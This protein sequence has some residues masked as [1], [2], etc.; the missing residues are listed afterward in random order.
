MVQEKKAAKYSNRLSDSA[1]S[2]FL[3]K[4]KYKSHWYGRELVAIGQ[5]V[6]SSKMCN[7]CNHIMDYMG[8]E[9]REWTCPICGTHHD[10]DINAAINILHTALQVNNEKVA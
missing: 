3:S 6:P 9:I 2:S 8:E 10:R 7:K 5:Y 4:L 1:M